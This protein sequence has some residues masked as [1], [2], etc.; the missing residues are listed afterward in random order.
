MVT[1]Y[2]D[3][4]W[5]LGELPVYIIGGVGVAWEPGSNGLAI[6]CTWGSSHSCG[7]IQNVVVVVVGGGG[8]GGGVGVVVVR[9]RH[10]WSMIAGEGDG[11]DGAIEPVSLIG[12]MRG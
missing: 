5:E 10:P 4:L 1:E 2:L 9:L 7:N 8:G 3:Y 12:P 6:A 11:L